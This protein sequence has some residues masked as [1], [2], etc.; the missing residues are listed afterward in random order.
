MYALS[1]I[2]FLD[3]S[4]S[5]QTH[6][7]PFLR[8]G[9]SCGSQK[10]NDMIVAWKARMDQEEPAEKPPLVIPSPQVA[11]FNLQGGKAG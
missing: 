7:N 2:R 9:G 11:Y 6:I 10:R 8:T 5:S 4:G 1:P 3:I